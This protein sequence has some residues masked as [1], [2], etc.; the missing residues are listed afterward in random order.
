MLNYRSQMYTRI[1]PAQVGLRLRSIRRSRSLSLG[2]VEE[3]SKGKRK[4][5][6]LGSYERGTRN[7]TVKR[8]IEIAEIYNIPVDQLLSEKVA[9]VLTSIPRLMLDI[10]RLQRLSPDIENSET[11]HPA[12]L[13][14]LLRRIVEERQDWNGEVITL[15]ESDLGNLEILLATSK[16][17]LIKWLIASGILL[18]KRV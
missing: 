13:L 18:Q 6:V 15:R 11:Q 1:T 14:R 3:L 12:L 10:R 9:E 7:L 2:D 17:D 16:D 4:A 5:V 8:A